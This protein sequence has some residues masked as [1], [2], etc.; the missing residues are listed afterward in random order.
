MFGSEKTWKVLV[1]TKIVSSPEKY[2][3]WAIGRARQCRHW[4]RVRAGEHLG[5]PVGSGTRGA[6]KPADSG[7]KRQVTQP[8]RNPV[9]QTKQGCNP[10][11]PDVFCSA[12]AQLLLGELSRDLALT[13]DSSKNHLL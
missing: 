4:V 11:V 2:L 5:T 10:W 13:A 12:L 1:G 6:E 9:S 8:S 3:V 7:K